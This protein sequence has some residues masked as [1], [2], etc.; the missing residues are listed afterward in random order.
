MG[1]VYLRV[2]MYARAR[3]LYEEARRREAF[4]E[5]QGETVRAVGVRRCECV[6]VGGGVYYDH[7]LVRECT[8]LLILIS[9]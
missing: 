6:C 4:K 2:H 8:C 3:G 9:S 1:I 7:W 5:Q